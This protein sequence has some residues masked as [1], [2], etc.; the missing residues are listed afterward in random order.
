MNWMTPVAGTEAEAWDRLTA[1]VGLTGAS[2]GQNWSA[3]AGVPTFG[4]VVEHLTR[5]PY[6]ALLRIDGPAPGIASLGTV[7]C[8]S[9][10][11]A[12][13]FT[14]FGD[15]AANAVES[16]KPKWDDWFA[17]RFPAPAAR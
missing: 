7:D 17:Q 9:V 14:F 6:D 4:G 10:M 8:G 5:K 12:V 16:E 3:P 1:A 2:V 13:N 15:H 11:V